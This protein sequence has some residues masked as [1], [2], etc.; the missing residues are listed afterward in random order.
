M[1]GD[2]TATTTTSP[3]ST[4][5]VTG[6]VGI[7]AGASGTVR[8]GGP[9]QNGVN[10][11]VTGIT[12]Q[13]I[14]S[15]VAGSVNSVAPVRILSGITLTSSDGVLGADRSPTAPYSPNGQLDYYNP[16]TGQIET[17]LVAGDAL[18]D[19]AIYASTIQQSSGGL[20]ISGPRVFPAAT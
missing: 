9:A 17:T 4:F 10:G 8:G 5:I 19:G 13:S 18:I 3:L 7:V 11:D 12:T 2:N 16:T 1:L 6:N 20:Q 15:I 14:L